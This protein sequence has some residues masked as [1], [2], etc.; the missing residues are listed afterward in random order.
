LIPLSA[1]GQG[2]STSLLSAYAV[3][4]LQWHRRIRRVLTSLSRSLWRHNREGAM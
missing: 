4:Y 2:T 3:T 1:I